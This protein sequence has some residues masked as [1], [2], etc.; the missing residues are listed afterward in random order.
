MRK[1]IFLLASLFLVPISSCLPSEADIFTE[2]DLEGTISKQSLYI[3]SIFT[4]GLWMDVLHVFDNEGGNNTQ[5]SIL[6]A[7]TAAPFTNPS[8]SI[9]TLRGHSPYDITGGSLYNVLPGHLFRN[10]I[11]RSGSGDFFA[12]VEYDQNVSIKRFSEDTR[13]LNNPRRMPS[14]SRTMNINNNFFSLFATEN[15][16][17]IF[18][19]VSAEEEIIYQIIRLDIDT[20]YEEIIVNRRFSFIDNSGDFISNIFAADHNIYVFRTEVNLD[21][22]EITWIDQYDFYGNLIDSRLIYTENFLYMDQVGDIDT[23]IGIY[24]VRDY[25]ILQ[26]LHSRSAVFREQGDSFIEVK[27]PESLQMIGSARLLKDWGDDT[28]YMYFWNFE[29][30]SLY[31]FDMDNYAFHSILINVDF[32]DILFTHQEPI[33]SLVFRSPRGDLMFGVESDVRY[34][35]LLGDEAINQGF[36][37]TL[38]FPLSLESLEAEL[39][40]WRL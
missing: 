10:I 17:I 6:V 7:Y 27:I 16:L 14:F 8:S 15:Y 38:L 9:H 34:A 35:E 32:E 3:D 13:D 21:A 25:F 36:G 1:L 30:R 40:G 23:V 28:K 20:L 2:Y 26:T 39:N 29:D 4:M 5:S 37:S 33:V 12:A 22:S 24:K 19:I 11:A 31:V 18:E